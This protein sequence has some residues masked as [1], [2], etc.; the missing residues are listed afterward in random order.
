MSALLKARLAEIGSGERPTETP[1]TSVDVQFNPTTLRVQISNRTAGG[2]QAGAQ[3]RQRPGTGEM[4]VSFDLV[5]DTADEGSTESGVSVL[6]K[7][8]MVERFVRPRGPR[9]GQEAPPRVL[10]AW[11]SFLVQGT[12]ESA[13]LDLDLFDANGV[14]LRAKVSVSIKGQDPRWTYTPAPANA[15]A[16]AGAPAG[17][18]NGSA[19][20][21]GSPGTQGNQQS[22][23]RIVQAMPG[24]SLAQLAARNGFDAKAWRALADGLSNP[25]RLELGQEVALPAAAGR[26]VA[27][28]GNGQGSD[29]AKTAASLPLVAAPTGAAGGGRAA[30][31]RSASGIDPVHQGQALASQGGLGGAIAQVKSAAHQQGASSSLAAFG[32]TSGEAADS[33]DRPWG[34]GVPL[35]PRFGSAL[36]AARRDPTQPGWATAGKLATSSTPALST[37]SVGRSMALADCGCRGRRARRNP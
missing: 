11:G 25:L 5:F 32:L 20:P 4:Q 37:A 1:N 34:A 8:A 9:P 29:P 28:G 15:A 22:P 19:L 17:S 3:A 35:R 7:T 33:A 2:A 10:F 18:S 6:D 21:A 23:E 27:S 36:P 16:A 26:G 31:A 30:T 13:N 24:E 14:P 12:M